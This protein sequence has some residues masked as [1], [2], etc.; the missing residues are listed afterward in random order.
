MAGVWTCVMAGLVLGCGAVGWTGELPAFP[1]AEGFGSTTPGGRG[2]K[3]LFVTS[4]DD[5]GPG[6][7]REACEAEGS[8]IVV[9]RVSGL[10]S[11]QKPI[12][13]RNPYLTL[14]GQSA[15]G[16]G[17]CLRNYPL[18]VATHDV[19]VRFLRS[20][21]GD[22]AGRAEDCLDLA[23]GAGHVIFDHCSA[24]WSIDECLSLAGNV[25]DATVQWCLI[26]EALNNSKHPK[27]PHG[28]GSLARA[29]GPV[30]LHHNL[31]AHH[32]ARSPRFGDNYD[33]PPYPVFDFRNNVIYDFGGTCSG[34]TQGRFPVNYVANYIRPGPSSKARTPITIGGPSDLTFFIR[35]NIFEGNDVLT[36]DNTQFF[37]RVEIEGTPQVR[38]VDKPFAAAPVKTL[39]AKEAFEAVLAM[40]GASVPVRDAVDARIVDQVRQHKGAIIDSQAQVGGWPEYRQSLPPQDSDSDG[41]PDTWEAAHELDP[42]DPSDSSKDRDGD[43]YT[44]IEEYLNDLVLHPRV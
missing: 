9:F 17:I 39:S 19:V 24:T 22:L 28:Y 14:A 10:I 25:S 29:N 8:R 11:L 32:N 13:V 20:R 15:P 23:N 1:G 26:A 5:S 4:L 27:G 38:I 40:V 21:L 41:M 12:T 6:S 31:W 30:S 44:N 34:L 3:V 16:D 36:A 33:R 42:Q 18:A 2:G 43:G 37:N 7:L 35:D